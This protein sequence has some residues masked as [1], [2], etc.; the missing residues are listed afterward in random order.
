A[1]L[2]ELLLLLRVLCAQG[3]QR[4]LE[5]LVAGRRIRGAR[6]GRAPLL[7]HGGELPFERF[8]LQLLPIELALPDFEERL[9]RIPA[10]GAQLVQLLAARGKSACLAQ[11]VRPHG[12]QLLLSLV[13]AL[14]GLREARP[15]ALGL[16]AA[17]GEQLVQVG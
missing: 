4:S 9:R 6:T 7:A 3:L 8:D 11:V 17:G 14:L 1:L 10:M 13:Q 2:L 15:Q 5:L 12:A 16:G